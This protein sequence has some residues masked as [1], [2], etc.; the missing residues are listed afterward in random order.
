MSRISD[1]PRTT[2]TKAITEHKTN[3]QQQTHIR[4][5]GTGRKKLETHHPSIENQIRQIIEGKTYG[6][7]HEKS[8]TPQSA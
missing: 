8:S 4:K 6:D 3:P 7:S 5:A 2:L 1:L